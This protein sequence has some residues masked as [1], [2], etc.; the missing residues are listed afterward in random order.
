MIPW[1]EPVEVDTSP[2]A[3]QL[4]VPED[5]T[6]WGEPIPPSPWDLPVLGARGYGFIR[7]VD[8]VEN[9]GVGRLHRLTIK[10]HLHYAAGAECAVDEKIICVS[11]LVLRTS[12]PLS[13]LPQLPFPTRR[14]ECRPWKRYLPMDID[15]GQLQ[16]THEESFA[17]LRAILAYFG[18]R[19]CPADE[20]VVET[21][22]HL[23][24]AY[25]WEIIEDQDVT[26][27]ARVSALAS[28]GK[29]N[30]PVRVDILRRCAHGTL[31]C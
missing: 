29:A 30:L 13:G 17:E 19:H 31:H 27:D 24:A 8:A 11:F 23:F 22:W 6:P 2:L 25:V 15:L 20:V 21:H 14:C 18:A 7:L 1:G 12:W 4:Q 3:E 26:E 5:T 16:A 10:V 28:W 9:S